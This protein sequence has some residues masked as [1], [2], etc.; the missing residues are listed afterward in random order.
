VAYA[1]SALEL[2][3]AQIGINQL[4]KV[5]YPDG[6]NIRFYGW[7]DSFTPGAHKEGDQPTAAMVIHPSM[8]DN[9]GAEHGPVYTAPGDESSNLES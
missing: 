2:I 9:N 6:S 4:V 5:H 3:W 7:I 8:R 1:T